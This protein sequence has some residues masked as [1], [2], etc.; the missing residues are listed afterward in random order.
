MKLLG[1]RS[2]EDLKPEMLELMD[3]LVGKQLGKPE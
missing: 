2:I 1:A 3:G